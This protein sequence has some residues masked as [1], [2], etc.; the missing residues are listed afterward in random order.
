MC[1]PAFLH[2]NTHARTHAYIII[3]IYIYI[4]NTTGRSILS[5]FFATYV[6]TDSN[7][8]YIIDINESFQTLLR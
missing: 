5:L 1:M 7:V 8:R 4:Y 6:N 2:E 3:Y